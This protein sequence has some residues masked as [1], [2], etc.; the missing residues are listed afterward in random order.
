MNKKINFFTIFISIFILLGISIY[1]GKQHLDNTFQN[2]KAETV[3][4]E[5]NRLRTALEEYYQIANHYPNLSKEGASNNLKMLDYIDENGKKISFADIY[6]Q[7][8]IAY[9]PEMD[10]VKSSNK[11]YNRNFFENGTQCG[12]WNYDYSTQTGEIH[13][14]LKK[15][16]YNQGINWLEY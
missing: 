6:K 1:L 9:T 14:N 13:A 11:V 10:N 7:N 5:L 12:G 8:E 16:T 15:N 3:I 2:N 4:R